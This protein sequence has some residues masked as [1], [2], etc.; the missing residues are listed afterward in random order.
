M[1]RNLW[2]AAAVL[3]ATIA[4]GALP[5]TASAQ[6]LSLQ[7][8]PTSVTTNFSFQLDGLDC[9]LFSEMQPIGTESAPVTIV[10]RHGSASAQLWSW[11]KAAA[12][13]AI[14][15]RK[16]ADLV[17][18]RTDGTPVARYHLQNAWP[19]KMEVSE[20]DASKNEVSIETLTL[21]ADHAQRIF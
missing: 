1:F 14:A 21:V 3:L 9:G 8:P 11:Q 10:L 15:S 6:Q 12:S 5:L 13:G 20:F 19:S 18:Y 16:D 4:T 17:M 2:R 7:P